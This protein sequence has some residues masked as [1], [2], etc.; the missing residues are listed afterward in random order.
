MSAIRDIADRKRI[1]RDL[2]EKNLELEKAAEAKNRFLA[3]MS[4]ELRTPLNAIIGFTGTL[5][6]KLPGPLTIEQEKQLNTVRTS[7]KHLLSLI[8]DLL[9]LAKIESGKVE[10]N[11]E[12]M[13]CGLLLEE[14]ASQLQPMANEKGIKFEVV[15]P[16]QDL[17]TRTDRRAFSQIAMNL[18]TNAIKFTDEGRVTLTLRYE[19]DAPNAVTIV[20]VEDTGCGI[21][22]SDQ[23]LL[24]KAFTQLDSSTTREHKGT[25]LGLHLSDKLADLIGGSITCESEVGIGSTFRLTI[26]AK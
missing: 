7:A 26:P 14:V 13:A 25:G 15:V 10:L 3:T 5:L 4:H 18:V 11:L 1:E 22:Q 20:E 16:Q 17:N 6:M 23:A 19:G 21:S 8:N 24:F 9:D 12:P 2:Y